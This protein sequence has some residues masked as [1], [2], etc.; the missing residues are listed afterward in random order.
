MYD[1]AVAGQFVVMP[2]GCGTGVLDDAMRRQL[3]E[4]VP[5]PVVTVCSGADILA[6][7]EG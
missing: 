3:P 6:L 4:G 5:E 1:L 2:V 7:V